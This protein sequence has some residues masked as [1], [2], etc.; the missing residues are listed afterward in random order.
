MLVRL[1]QL[2]VGQVILSAYTAALMEFNCGGKE[3]TV[4]KHDGISWAFDSQG[5]SNSFESVGVVATVS[6]KKTGLNDW[7]DREMKLLLAPLHCDQY[8][9]VVEISGERILTGTDVDFHPQSDDR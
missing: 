7:K 5:V 6:L 1:P 2:Y 3:W 8:Y 9:N 4:K